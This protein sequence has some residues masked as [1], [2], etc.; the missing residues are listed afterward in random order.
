[1]ATLLQLAAM[2]SP[3]YAV[4]AAGAPSTH[5]LFVLADDL[6]RL[7]NRSQQEATPA[8]SWPTEFFILRELVSVFAQSARVLLGGES[9]VPVAP[10]C[11]KTRKITL[12]H[13]STYP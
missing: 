13:P 9:Q 8:M 4:A 12:P 3:I 11:E 7:S 6:V 5:V 2:A 10:P 1:M